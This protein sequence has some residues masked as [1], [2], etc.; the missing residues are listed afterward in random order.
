MNRLSTIIIIIVAAVIIGGYLTYS[1]L[2][3]ANSTS[4]VM[5]AQD[6]DMVSVNYTGKLQDGTVFDS[7]DK[8]GRPISFVL[9]AGMVIKGWDEGILGM[10]IGDKKTLEIPPEKAYGA[11]GIPD[12]KGGYIIPPN[13]TL[14]FDVELVDIKRK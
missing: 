12:G 13:A 9:G 4:S 7:S 11:Q 2:H 5:T 6:G 1:S 10:K 3:M 8:Q 14:T